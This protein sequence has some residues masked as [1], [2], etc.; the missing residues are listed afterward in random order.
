MVNL[1][2][3]ISHILWRVGQRRTWPCLWKGQGQC[4]GLA[5]EGDQ[6]LLCGRRAPL[7]SCVPTEGC[8]QELATL[9]RAPGRTGN[10]KSW[11]Q[12]QFL[13]D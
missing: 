13:V 3:T 1:I 7:G 6:L 4:L 9:P 10:C 12:R 5:L 2:N 11:E 8:E